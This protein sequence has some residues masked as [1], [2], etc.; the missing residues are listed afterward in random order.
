MLFSSKA[1][2]HIFRVRQH[3][4]IGSEVSVASTS[5]YSSEDELSSCDNNKESVVVFRV[6]SLLW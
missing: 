1:I 2:L 5:G 6:T 3:Q 4:R